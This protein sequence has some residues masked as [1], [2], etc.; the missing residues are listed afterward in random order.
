MAIGR[1]RWRMQRPSQQRFL[2]GPLARSVER[3]KKLNVIRGQQTRSCRRGDRITDQAIILD[4]G[5]TR[6]T[7]YNQSACRRAPE[8]KR[9]WR[10]GLIALDGGELR[11]IFDYRPCQNFRFSHMSLSAA[12]GP[13]NPHTALSP[14]DQCSEPVA[15]NNG[16]PRFRSGSLFLVLAP[17]HPVGRF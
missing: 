6:P 15:S 12:A 1:Y 5:E 2:R 11:P 14:E 4:T 8:A 9:R 16:R 17:F 3:F 10:S 7:T 13:T